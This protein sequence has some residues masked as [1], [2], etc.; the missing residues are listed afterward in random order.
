[1]RAA[2]FFKCKYVIII[3]S[4]ARYCH[5]YSS[6]LG[7]SFCFPGEPLGGALACGG[8]PPV[9]TQ[10]RGLRIGSWRACL[11]VLVE[12]YYC[13]NIASLNCRFSLLSKL[14]TGLTEGHFFYV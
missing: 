10:C 14:T 11:S 6:K 7:V 12:A 1:M 2:P 9:C 5:V 4:R 3:F 13:T 8:T